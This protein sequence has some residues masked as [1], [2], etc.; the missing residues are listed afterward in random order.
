VLLVRYGVLHTAM[1]LAHS[2]PVLTPENRNSTLLEGAR[3]TSPPLATGISQQSQQSQQSGALP[4]CGLHLLPWALYAEYPGLRSSASY[5]YPSPSLRPRPHHHV[6][7]R[8]ESSA[9]VG[10]ALLLQAPAGTA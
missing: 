4:A 2:R 6:L 3:G 9:N 1:P 7:C 5:R 8:V 10:R